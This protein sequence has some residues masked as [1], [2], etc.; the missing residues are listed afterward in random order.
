MLFRSRG[1]GPT[2]IECDTYRFYNH[3][4]M[5]EG[6]PRPRAER[7][8][9]RMRDPIEILRGVLEQRAI[10]SGGGAERVLD[11]VRLEIQEAIAFAE[12]S[13]EPTPADLLTDVYT[14]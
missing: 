11:E 3:T 14:A 2:L 12:A 10:L 5:G 9:W 6:D 13:P 8:R 4:G 1:E 7:E